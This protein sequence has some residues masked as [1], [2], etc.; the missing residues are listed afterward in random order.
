MKVINLFAGPGAG[1]ST[2]AA[3]LFNHLKV[4]G[5]RAELVTEFAKELVYERNFERLNNQLLV[6]GEQEQ[7]LRRLIPSKLDYVITDSPLLLSIIYME[8]ARRTEAYT[9]TVL[10]LFDTYDNVNFIINRVKPYQNYGRTQSEGE[11]RNL[12]NK[13]AAMLIAGKVPY[14][15]VNGDADAAATIFNLLMKSENN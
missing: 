1:K 12:D 5:K 9:Q 6:L 13:I 10:E 14:T 11:A 2:T 8:K 15:A 4:A 7:R 3:G